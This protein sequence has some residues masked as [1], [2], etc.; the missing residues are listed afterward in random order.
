VGQLDGELFVEVEIDDRLQRLVGSAVAHRFG[1][2]VEPGGVLGLQRNQ[3]SDCRKP[4]LWS[5]AGWCGPIELGGAV[6]LLM[7]RWR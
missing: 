4:A 1:N 3:F 2:T 6:P 7:W 5:V